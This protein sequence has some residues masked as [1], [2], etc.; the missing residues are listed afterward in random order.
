[1]INTPILTS[2]ATARP[3]DLVFLPSGNKV[4]VKKPRP[5]F[6]LLH[7]SR[8]EEH[9]HFTAK[10]SST[11]NSPAHDNPL[12]P[13]QPPTWISKHPLPLQ[14]PLLHDHTPLPLISYA[15][16]ST[17]FSSSSSPLLPPSQP[18][19]DSTWNLSISCPYRLLTPNLHQDS[20]YALL[21]P[22]LDSANPPLESTYLSFSRLYLPTSPPLPA[23]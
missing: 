22:L 1:M 6:S 18:P 8:Y 23:T 11:P 15:F 19:R 4:T 16:G 12:S 5:R 14:P 20:A 2:L 3:H 21:H 10:S 17:S 7:H 13:L 9:S